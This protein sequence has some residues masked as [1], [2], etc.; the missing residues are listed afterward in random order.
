MNST[1]SSS[2]APK[3]MAE[4]LA[5]AKSKIVSFTSGQ[6]VKGKVLAKSGKSLIL[7]IGGKSEGVVTEKAFIEARE[8]IKDLKVGDEV[9]ATVIIPETKDGT[10][11]LSLRQAAFDASWERLIKAKEAKLEIAVLGKGVNPSGVT[12]EVEGLLGFIPQS[13]LGKIASK[14]SQ[15][16]VGKYFKALI[17]EVDK[18]ANKIVLSEK[19][20][21]EAGDIKLEKEALMKIKEGEIYDG[22]VTT[23][24]NFGCFV[25][26]GIGTQKEKIYVEGLVHISELAWGK[27]K[28]SSDVVSTGDKVKVKVI[29]FKDGKLSL[30]IKAAKEDPWEKAT[31]KYKPEM[32]VVGVVSKISDFGA[33]VEVEPGVEGLIHTTKIPPGKKLSEGEKVTCYV[34][35]IDS[36]AHKLSL[37]LVLT[38]KPIGYK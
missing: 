30:S 33:F 12:V 29:G 27:V 6:K 24:A 38:S 21:S 31:T 4:L 11:L 20:I 28:N 8:F 5:S 25:K 18:A 26:I 34:E 1:K 13:Q 23:V 36:K 2:K 10:V 32:K 16:L 15:D 9:W 19:A 17:L 3:T 14:S 35:N 37:G 22:E 7:D